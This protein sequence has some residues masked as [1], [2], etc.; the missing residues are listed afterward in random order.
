VAVAFSDRRFAQQI[1]EL[2]DRH[3]PLSSPSPSS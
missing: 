1:A 2:W 3:P